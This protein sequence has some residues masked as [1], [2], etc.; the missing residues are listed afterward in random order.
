MSI[1]KPDLL[2]KIMILG[3]L[4]STVACEGK[5]DWYNYQKPGSVFEQDLGACKSRAEDMAIEH[6][7]RGDEIVLNTYNANLL[8][9]LYSKGWTHI[10][11]ESL[12]SLQKR[13]SNQVR[14]N[15]Q[16]NVVNGFGERIHL[17]SHKFKL[18]HANSSVY[19]PGYIKKINFQGPNSIYLNFVF[20]ENLAKEFERTGFKVD[21]AFVQYSSGSESLGAKQL[22]WSVYFGEYNGEWVMGLGCY[23]LVSPVKRI[24]IVIT[25]NMIEPKKDPVHPLRLTQKQYIAVSEFEAKWLDWIRTSLGANKP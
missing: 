12:N 4:L 7:H 11:P 20:Q 14:F 19:G 21:T 5:R 23:V 15:G 24:T 16:K 17:K 3:L 2:A 8:E 25:R 22:D 6:S 18:L 13:F 10:T 9:C 1:R